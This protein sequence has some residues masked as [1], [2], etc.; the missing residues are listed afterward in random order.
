MDDKLFPGH[1]RNMQP[2]RIATLIKRYADLLEGRMG[3]ELGALGAQGKVVDLNEFAFD[4]LVRCAYSHQ[5]K[6][7][8][9]D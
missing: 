6:Q 5:A 4:I 8:A 2:G 1:H 9:A 3:K 7:K